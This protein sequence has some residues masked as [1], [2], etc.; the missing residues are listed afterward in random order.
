MWAD[1]VCVC[2][3][4]G[5]GGGEEEGGGGLRV[6]MCKFPSLPSMYCHYVYVHISVSPTSRFST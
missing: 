4:G 6:C 3:G 5:G 1:Q 2:V